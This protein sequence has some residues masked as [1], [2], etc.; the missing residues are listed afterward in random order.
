VV[1]GNCGAET[2]GSGFNGTRQK[3]GI[4][5]HKSIGYGITDWK[6][7]KDPRFTS[8]MFDDGW[9]DD[10]N[11]KDLIKWV[12]DKDNLKL[13]M[14]AAKKERLD[15][16]ISKIQLKTFEKSPQ[17]VNSNIIYH[18]ESGPVILFQPFPHTGT[19]SRYDDLIDYYEAGTDSRSKVQQPKSLRSGIYPYEGYLVRFRGKPLD[20]GSKKYKE[21]RLDSFVF[22]HLLEDDETDK[23]L[24]EDLKNNWRPS[25]PV[26]IHAL[27]LYTGIVKDVASFVDELR[28]M[29]YTHWS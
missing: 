27:L 15:S 23:A 21:G 5:I 18:P 25:I 19:W 20:G 8:K 24:V 28:P 3:M 7:E 14:K 2:I 22:H 29:I 12:E 11:L 4:R 9:G 1:T 16:L 26:S 10:L 17:D 6:R 13:I